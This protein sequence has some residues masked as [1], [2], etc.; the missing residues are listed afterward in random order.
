MLI[1]VIASSFFASS[2]LRFVRYFV[3]VVPSSEAISLDRCE[4][5]T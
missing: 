3:K 5:L 1:S 2:I 4:T